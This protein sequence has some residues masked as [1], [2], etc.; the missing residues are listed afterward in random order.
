MFK[1]PKPWFTTD[2]IDYIE[3]NI[4]S[5]DIVLEFGGGASSLY[6]ANKVKFTYTV[7]ANVSWAATLLQKFAKHPKLLSKWSMLFVP[8]DWNHKHYNPKSYWR[9]NSTHLSSDQA[10]HLESLYAHMSFAFSPSVI[11]IDGSVRP[12]TVEATQ[13]YLRSHKET[14]KMIIIDNME[15]MERYLAGGFAGY[16]RHDFPEH[17]LTKIPEHQNGQWMT[18]VYLR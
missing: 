10:I 15:T 7:E 5:N 1:E 18:S 3:S 9:R 8:C 16:Q 4:N 12:Q 6:W 2:S 11:V 17:D 14:L 13:R